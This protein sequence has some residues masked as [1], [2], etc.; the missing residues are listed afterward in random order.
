MN[1]YKVII[2]FN[3]G[4]QIQSKVAAWN[5]SDALQRIMT[6]EQAID[7][8]ASHAD[9]KNVDITFIGEYEDVP[10]DPNRFVLTPSQER[11]G[12]IVAADR[13]TN[14]VFIFMEG[15]FPDSVEYKPLED[16]TPLDAATAVRELGDWLRLYHRDLLEDKAEKTRYINR[17]RVGAL[18]A[19]ARKKQGLTVRELAEKSG[20]SYQN[21]TK[22]ENGKYNVSIDILGK[23]CKA[24]DL[25]IDLSGY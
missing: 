13:K 19:E 14:M 4:D 23:L 9:V 8:I 2:T 6:N 25:K 11:N 12:W 15:V 16:M 17:M 3:D 21:I 10:N 20:V 5:Q 22:I 1:Q 7:F 18:I 24:L